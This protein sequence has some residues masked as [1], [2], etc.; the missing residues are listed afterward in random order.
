MTK[1][2]SFFLLP[3][4]FCTTAP[5]GESKE[6][7]IYTDFDDLKAGGMYETLVSN[8]SLEVVEKKGVDGSKAL[9]AK[10]EGYKKG[11]KRITARCKLP[12]K[13]KEATLVFD[14]MFDEEFQFVKGGKLLGFGPDRPI[15][16]GK[17]MKPDGWSARMM[18]RKA[19][20]LDTYIYCQNKKGSYGI[21]TGHK[22]PF[23]FKKG[24]YYA[25][26]MYVK[27]NEPVS[28]E[29]GC[30][31]VIVNGQTLCKHENIQ[32][33]KVDG[34]NTL[35][36]NFMFCTFHGGSSKSWA[37]KTKDGGYATV[38]AFYDNI[39]VYKGMHVRKKPGRPQYC[40]PRSD[41]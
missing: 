27:I 14:L 16:G 15:T 40:A 28:A 22:E 3:V 34:D 23:N 32:F 11:S 19:G 7:L 4:I 24:V 26:S 37:P 41:D 20:G 13:V 9:R 39:A 17:S 36:S 33:R 31:H 38:Y 5:A 25:I 35:I 12:E 18:W 8:G 21:R 10:Y 29:N 2:L 1:A 30:V 6:P